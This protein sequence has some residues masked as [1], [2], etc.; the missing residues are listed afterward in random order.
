MSKD[1]CRRSLGADKISLVAGAMK[2][3]LFSLQLGIRAI[4]ERSKRVKTKVKPD[5]KP[6]TDK[7]G[8][9]QASRNLFILMMSRDGLEP[10]THWLKASCSTD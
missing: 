7:N 5:T 4:N 6:D 2:S 8:R 9:R 10:S 1:Q 3:P